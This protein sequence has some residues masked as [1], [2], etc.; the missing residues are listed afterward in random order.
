VCTTP[1]AARWPPPSSTTTPRARSRSARPDRR[2]PTG[3]T[4]PWSRPWPR[5]ASTC[6]GS[7][8]RR[9]PTPRSRPPM[10]SSPWAAATPAP[11]IRASAMRTGSSRTPPAS[12]SRSCAHP[13]SDRPT[14]PATPHRTRPSFNLMRLP[15]SERPPA[16]DGAGS[17]AAIAPGGTGPYGD[18]GEGQLAASMAPNRPWASSSMPA[19][20]SRVVGLPV[21]PLP[22]R[23]AHRPSI[24]I[25]LPSSWR[26]RPRNAPVQGS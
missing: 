14:R 9:S 24:S 8:P 26:R 17:G 4:R 22:K 25:G 3:S 15:C 2:R 7:S 21:T 6:R 20:N 10:W 12:R 19:V 1:A 16:V 18:C 11:S 23:S 13:R 5:S